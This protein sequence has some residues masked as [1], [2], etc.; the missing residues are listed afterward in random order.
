MTAEGQIYNWRIC[1]SLE[2]D[3]RH[4]PHMSSLGTNLSDHKNARVHEFVNCF[5][6]SSFE[7]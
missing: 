4:R 7:I 3:N 5:Q 1:L 2:G 6:A